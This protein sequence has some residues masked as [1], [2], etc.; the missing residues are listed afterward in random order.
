MQNLAYLDG[1]GFA[2]R[3]L[4]H[5]LEN[6]RQMRVE[7]ILRERL[8]D[9]LGAERGERSA[10]KV[11]G[12]IQV[13]HDGCH[14][15]A[16]ERRVAVFLHALLLLAAQLV[17]MLVNALEA[18]VGSQQL[19]RRLV[20]H[21]RHAGDVVGAV[22]FKAQEIGELR[23]LHAVTLAHLAGAVE[24]HVGD[25]LARGD[26]VRELG[27]QL[28]DVL[29]ARDQQRAIAQL[30]VARRNGSQ[31]IV[32][33]PARHAHHG[34]AHGFEQLL[35]DGELRLQA[36]VHGRA[37]GLVLLE[38]LGAELRAPGIEGAHDGVGIGDVDELE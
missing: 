35:D 21:A 28:V 34:D 9:G 25:A 15:A 10:L 16:G 38:R 27:A 13:A 8:G 18:A 20:A 1:R 32:A 2:L 4:A 19:R 11:Q 30:L 14:L 24:G 3:S 29:I 22:A 6:A 31:D 33:L 7:A 5:Q 26:H 23:R 36:R 37:L 17:D 12:E